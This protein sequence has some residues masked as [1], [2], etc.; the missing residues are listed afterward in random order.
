MKA[1]QVIELVL[2]HVELQMSY[3]HQCFHQSFTFHC[4]RFAR[5]MFD[6]PQSPWTTHGHNLVTTLHKA[7]MRVGGIAQTR[8]VPARVRIYIIQSSFSVTSH[9]TAPTRSSVSDFIPVPSFVRILL[10]RELADRYGFVG[11]TTTRR[12]H[13]SLKP[14]V[15]QTWL[16]YTIPDRSATYRLQINRPWM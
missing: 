2:Y 12:H 4:P 14:C 11:G 1:A 5:L 10:R 8:V 6:P 9:S 7:L 15:V 13:S 16:W 3:A